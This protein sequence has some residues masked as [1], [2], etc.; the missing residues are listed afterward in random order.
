MTVALNDM[1]VKERECGVG[2]PRDD[3]TSLRMCTHTHIHTLIHK[4]TNIHTKSYEN[5]SITISLIPMACARNFAM[6]SS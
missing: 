4:H 3:K 2:L 5:A 1:Q 6:F